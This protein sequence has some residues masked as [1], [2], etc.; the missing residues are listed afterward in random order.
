MDHLYV[1]A[2]LF[3]VLTLSLSS[4]FCYLKSF[5]KKSPH[6]PPGPRGLPILGYLPFLGKN[7][8]QTFTDLGHKY[9]PI[10]KIYLGNKLCVVISS[11]SLVKEVVRNKDAIFATRDT[12]VAALVSFYGGKDIIFSNP[13]SHWVLM[14]KIFI[15]EMMSQTSLDL[16]AS[17]AL[18]KDVVRK[19]VRFVQANMGKPIQID[20]LTFQT[21]LHLVTNMMWGGIVEGELGAKIEAE[22]FVLVSKILDLLGKPKVSDLFPVLARFDMQGIKRQME[23][24]MQSADTIFEAVIA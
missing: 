14:R 10:F 19:A 13:N 6:L 12:T 11:P 22:F 3:S 23:G 1:V 9:G 8:L 18:R 21:S 20:H 4:I 16:E 2:I 24:Y 17:N 15:Q 5:L 7:F